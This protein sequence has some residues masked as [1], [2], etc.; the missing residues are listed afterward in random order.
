MVR[1]TTGLEAGG[2][3]VL[4]KMAKGTDLEIASQFLRDAKAADLSVQI[5]GVKKIKLL[6]HF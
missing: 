4:D 6:R 2:Q 5:N 3:A 1:V